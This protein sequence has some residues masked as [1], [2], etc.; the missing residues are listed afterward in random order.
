VTDDAQE[1]DA[2]HSFPAFRAPTRSAL[3][4]LQSLMK[5]CVALGQLPA[6]RDA[7]RLPTSDAEVAASSVASVSNRGVTLEQRRFME[8]LLTT[9]VKSPNRASE[10]VSLLDEEKGQSVGVNA[11]IASLPRCRAESVEEHLR[12]M[13]ALSVLSNSSDAEFVVCA[14]SGLHAVMDTHQVQRWLDAEGL[15]CGVMVDAQSTSA[16]AESAV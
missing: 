6:G 15:S 5:H 14:A 8:V 4:A 1:R 7:R 2:S 16:T 9:F 12:L 11:D 3:I 10:L 13:A